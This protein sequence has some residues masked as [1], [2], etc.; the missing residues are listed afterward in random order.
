MRSTEGPLLAL[1]LAVGALLPPLLSGHAA[2]E[3][4]HTESTVSLI[5][6]V[7]AV[8]AWVGAWPRC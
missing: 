1:A 4:F 6:C 3:G 5:V 7:V 8:S 2:A